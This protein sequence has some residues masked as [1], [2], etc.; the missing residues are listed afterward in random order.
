MSLKATMTIMKAWAAQRKGLTEQALSLY[1]EG[2]AAGGGDPRYMLAY[3][4][5]LI[6][7]GEF[8]KAKDLLVKHQRMPGMTPEQ[9]TELINDYAV[10]VYKLGEPEKAIAKMEE[11][12]RKNPTGNIY[13]TLGYFYVDQCDQAN[14]PADDE[15]APVVA[16]VPAEEAA[17][18]EDAVP[19]EA[20]KTPAQLF[21]ERLEKASVFLE[22][23]VE[24]DDEDPIVLDNLAQYYY[25]CLG[26]KQ[27]AKTWF[28]KAIAIKEGQIDTLWFLSRY[29]LE[30][31]NKDAALEKLTL[32]S[33]GRFS[34][35]NFKTKDEVLAEIERL[36]A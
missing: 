1:E 13:Q 36:K 32:A 4:I 17:E 23:A 33:E 2:F 28:E 34:P 16:E 18:G 19:Q 6:R 5:L 30:A 21:D 35:L 27:T 14:R 29:D 8:A 7:N 25:R 12:F 3:A 20:P 10:C 15:P 31:G 11:N 9:K 22:E 26:D 24:Y